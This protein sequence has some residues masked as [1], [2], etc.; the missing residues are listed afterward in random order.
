MNPVEKKIDELIAMGCLQPD[1]EKFN[2]FKNVVVP[3]VVNEWITPK[4]VNSH[5]FR[6]PFETCAVLVSRGQLLE[7][8]LREQHYKDLP[9]GVFGTLNSHI[10]KTCGQTFK[11]L[12]HLY[13]HFTGRKHLKSL[14][15]QGRI[16]KKVFVSLKTF[17]L[18]IATKEQRARW[19]EICNARREHIELAHNSKLA[20]VAIEETLDSLCS[21]SSSSNSFY[22]SSPSILNL[23]S[24]S[25][26]QFSSTPIITNRSKKFVSPRTKKD[27]DEN[28]MRSLR[29]SSS[30]ESEDELFQDLGFIN[31]L[32]GF[33]SKTVALCEKES[34]NIESF[35]RKRKIM[36]IFEDEDEIIDPLEDFISN[37]RSLPKVNSQ[38]EKLDNEIYLSFSL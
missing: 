12:E 14:I 38:G 23:S 26:N 15:S 34:C 30:Q 17:F 3:S 37:K 20:D 18:G 35:Q 29:I 16:V 13:K 22:S 28:N 1:D 24:L 4:G 27:V 11:R 19:E 10:C 2:F 21:E 8:H 9:I 5:S 33:E 36:S 32:N 7:R 6:C 25:Q 31:M